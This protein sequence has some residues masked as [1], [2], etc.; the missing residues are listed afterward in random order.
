MQR[1]PCFCVLCQV[2]LGTVTVRETRAQIID[3]QLQ[4]VMTQISTGDQ[5]P[6]QQHAATR[7]SRPVPGRERTKLFMGSAL[8]GSSARQWRVCPSI[9]LARSRF[10]VCAVV[11]YYVRSSSPRPSQR[12][13]QVRRI[14]SRVACGFDFGAMLIYRSR[15]RRPGRRSTSRPSR[16]NKVRGWRVGHHPT[17]RTRREASLVPFQFTRPPVLGDGLVV[18]RCR[19]CRLLPVCSPVSP[20][21]CLGSLWSCSAVSSWLTETVGGTCRRP[22]DKTNHEHPSANSTPAD[23]AA[24]DRVNH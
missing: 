21:P 16:P 11:T 20:S 17:K 23:R 10:L 13:H 14:K 1:R 3:A 18:P 2:P 15:P 22:S 4:L 8:V 9:S 19:A 7:D 12:T 24:N 6:H 5:Q